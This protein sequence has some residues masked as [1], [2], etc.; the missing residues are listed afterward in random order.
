MSSHNQYGDVENVNHRS[1]VLAQ[2]RGNAKAGKGDQL[3]SHKVKKATGKAVRCKRKTWLDSFL[4]LVET[5]LDSLA[6]F[7][8]STFSSFIQQSANACLLSL[9]WLDHHSKQKIFSDWREND[10]NSNKKSERAM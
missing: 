2:G 7:V 1:Y 9:E 10:I 5:L 4:F 8:R 6:R 3:S